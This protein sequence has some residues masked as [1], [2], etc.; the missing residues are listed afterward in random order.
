MCWEKSAPPARNISD[1][2][3]VANPTVI[4]TKLSIAVVYIWICDNP[5]RI[6]AEDINEAYREQRQRNSEFPLLPS[7]DNR[8]PPGRCAR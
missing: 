3:T 7:A 6:K 4:T 1:E 2:T 8:L 5:Y